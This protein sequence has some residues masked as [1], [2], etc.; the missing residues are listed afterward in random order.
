MTFIIILVI[1]M[2]DSFCVTVWPR[3][4]SRLANVMTIRNS[5]DMHGHG[6]AINVYV[7]RVA[8]SLVF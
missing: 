4:D 8:I 5:H 7:L 3:G 2:G 6:Q 1:V